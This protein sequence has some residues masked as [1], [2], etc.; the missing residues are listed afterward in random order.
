MRKVI[1]LLLLASSFAQDTRI[2]PPQAVPCDRNHLTAFPGEVTSFRRSGQL[3]ILT[4]RTDFDTVEKFRLA[5]TRP[6]LESQFLLDGRPF[7]ATDWNR[8]EVAPAQ[9]RPKTRATVW[10]CS[11][12]KSLI[13]DWFP[14]AKDS[15]AE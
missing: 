15:S 14:P 5:G 13:I 4:V 8:I 11:Q 6:K 7:T 9:L 10:Q 1:L 12:P 3:L 2:R